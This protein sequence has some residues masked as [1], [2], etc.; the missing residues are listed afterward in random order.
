MFRAVGAVLL[1]VLL[2]C[3]LTVHVCFI[4]L[5]M[6]LLQQIN[7]ITIINSNNKTIISRRTNM[8]SHYKGADDDDDDDDDELSYLCWYI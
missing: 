5:S 3:V 6:S 2:Y 1:T 7:M 8:A 4:V